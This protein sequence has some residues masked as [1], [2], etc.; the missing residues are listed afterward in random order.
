MRVA[1]VYDRV[2]KWGGAERVLLAL[3]EIFPEAPL[4]TSVCDFKKAPWAKIFPHVYTSFLQ[5]IP[6]LKNR[7]ELLGTFMPLVFETFEFSEFD[8][9]IS[10]TSEAA[11]GIV[12]KPPTKHFCYCLTPTRYLWS[13]YN[14]Y[15]KD[16]TFKAVT[17]PVISYLRDW[18][19]MAAQRPDKIIAISSAVRE[20]IKKY[21]HRDSQIIFPPVEVEKFSPI[22]S[23]VLHKVNGK[24]KEYYLVASRLVPYKRIDLVIQ[25]FNLLKYPLLIIGEGSQEKKLKKIAGKNIKFLGLINEKKLISCYQEAKALIMAQEEDFGLVAVEAQA[26]GTPVIAYKKGGVLDTVI[27]GKTGI[28][29]EKQNSKFLVDA[30]KRFDRMKFSS[31]NLIDNAKRF[32]KERF[33]KEFLNFIKENA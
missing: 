31:K 20:R 22:F 6:F 13:H 32:S 19:K 10:V 9:V 3:H 2:N 8:L 29:F 7:H 15:F 14:Q 26:A 33:N 27:E 17:K 30:V 5:K 28:F 21:Y 24:Q 18:D 1:L 23:P 4:F 16:P 25:A 11:K 12:V